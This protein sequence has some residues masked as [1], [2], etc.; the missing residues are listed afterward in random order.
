MDP[1]KLA[2]ECKGTKS[3]DITLYSKKCSANLID[4]IPKLEYHL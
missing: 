3:G 2:F 1:R 4:D